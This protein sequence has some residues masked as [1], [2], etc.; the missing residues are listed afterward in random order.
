MSQESHTVGSLVHGLRVPA[1]HYELIS[2]VSGLVPEEERSNIVASLTKALLDASTG[3]ENADR[4]SGGLFNQ[5]ASNFEH[6]FQ[7]DFNNVQAITNTVKL[8]GHHIVLT[9]GTFDILHVGHAQYLEKAKAYGDFLVVGVDSDQKVKSK[10]GEHR[11]IVP[12]QERLKMLSSIRGVDL[13]TLKNQEAEKWKLIKTIEPDTLIATEGSYSND[14]LDELESNHVGRV[15]VL[16]PQATTS[17]TARL[18]KVQIAHS[19]ASIQLLPE[20]LEQAFPDFDKSTI[21]TIAELSLKASL[22]D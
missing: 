17:T 14:E 11:P 21:N 9:S 7:P 10:K 6:R 3:F 2:N 12:E 8:M 22:G 16:P 15:V 18:R 19:H 13:L 20:L 5:N 1:E 4:Y